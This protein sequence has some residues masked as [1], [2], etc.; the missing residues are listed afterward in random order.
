V[1]VS[2]SESSVRAGSIHYGLW[3]VS[4]VTHFTENDWCCGGLS[5]LSISSDNVVAGK[6]YVIVGRKMVV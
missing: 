1:E 6:G 5:F 4:V 2:E 3:H